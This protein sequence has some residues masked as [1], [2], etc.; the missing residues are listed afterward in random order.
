MRLHDVLVV[1][2]E[3]PATDLARTVEVLDQD[4]IPHQLVDGASEAVARAVGD[5]PPLV[6]FQAARTEPSL[7]TTL[8]RLRSLDV[9]AL[10]LVPGA[11]DAD[12]EALLGA[13]A[14]DVVALPVSGQRLH[15]RLTAMHR[16]VRSRAV[17]SNRSEILRVHD[18]VIDVGRREAHAGGAPVHLTRTEFDLLVTLARHPRNVVTRETLQLQARGERAGSDSSLESHLC[19]LRAKIVA[20]D[21]PRLILPVRGVGYRLGS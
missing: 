1:S 15:A 6:V 14:L 2:L 17:D 16:F 13:G 19:R 9:P 7:V 4:A 10:V 12:E 18:L 5:R 21:G 8:Q 3:A 11:T 20:A